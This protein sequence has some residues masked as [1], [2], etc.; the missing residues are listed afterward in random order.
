MLIIKGLR[1]VSVKSEIY[2]AE[3]MED[4]RGKELM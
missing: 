1:N 3:R 4:D 2:A